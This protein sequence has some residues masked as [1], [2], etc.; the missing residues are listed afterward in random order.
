MTSWPYNFHSPS[1]FVNMIPTL[2][3]WIQH[4]QDLAKLDIFMS[5]F[6][7]S[8]QFEKAMVLLRNVL[9][10]F[11]VL[12]QNQLVCTNCPITIN[13]DNMIVMKRLRKSII[14]SF[15]QEYQKKRKKLKKLYDVNHIYHD[16]TAL[17][18][19]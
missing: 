16:Q 18:F 4:A 7:L 11:C 15:Y 13:S 14:R 8:P 2:I 12:Q 19:G 3:R 5:P 10:C 17:C 9:P 6:E 1:S